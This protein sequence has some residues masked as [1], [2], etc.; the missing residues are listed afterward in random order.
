MH[1]QPVLLRK[2]LFLILFSLPPFSSQ[3]EKPNIVLFIADDLT[4]WDLGC[5]GGQASTPNI[6]RIADEGMQFMRAYQ[7]V[8]VCG[9]TRHNLLTGLYPVRNGAYPQTGFVRPGVQSLPHYLRK[10]GYRT[11]YMGKR[12]I[13][14]PEAFPFEYITDDKVINFER[15]E[16]F[17]MEVGETPFVLIIGTTEPHYRWDKGDATA[18]PPESLKLPPNW[19]DTP[20]TRDYYSRYLGEVSYSD[21]EV[22][23][24]LRVLEEKGILDHTVFIYTSEQGA[25]F[26]YAKWTCYEAGVHT[27]FIVRWPGKVEADSKAYA[28]VEYTDVLPT[29]IDIAG[30]EVQKHLDG[31]SFLEV[32]TGQTDHHRDYLFS[33]QTT[34]GEP[35]GGDHFAVR[36]V[37]DARYT[38][39]WN[40]HPYMLFENHLTRYGDGFFNSWREVGWKNKEADKLFLGYITRPP[41][42]LYDRSVDPFEMHNLADDPAYREVI[43]HLDQQLKEWMLYCGDLGH[44]TEMAAYEHQWKNYSR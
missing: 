35:W 28:F 3:A 32:L 5:Y 15:M 12:H 38:Y 2:F 21:W 39:I 9:P 7:T 25:S 10:E 4:Y 11:A 43:L 22:G 23:E 14:P 41:I 29:M 13:Q 31:D 16:E 1:T 36:C 20:E 26:P 42:E 40:L 19:I 44:E 17:I 18:Y 27:A 24:T 6:D 8:A 33:M 37:R 34:R 30:G